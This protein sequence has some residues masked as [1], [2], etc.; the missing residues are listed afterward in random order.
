MTAEFENGKVLSVSG[1]RCPK[2]A[3]YVEQEIT[4]PVRNIASSVLVEGG[5]MPLCS[6]RLSGPVPKGRIMDVMAQIRKTRVSAPVHM[7]D[8]VI[9]DVLGLGCDVISTRN[10]EKQ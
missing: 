6:V 5:D 1:N 9:P 7:G 8:V 2:G 3:G 10:V 4:N